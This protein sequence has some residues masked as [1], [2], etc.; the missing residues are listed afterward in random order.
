[1]AA[2]LL[3]RRGRSYELKRKRRQL[4]GEFIAV[5]CA[6]LRGDDAM[7]ALFGHIKGAYTGAA[8]ARRGYLDQADGGVLFLDEIGDLGPDEQ[9][10]LL[11]AIED[12][13]FYPVGADI[14]TSSESAHR[15]HQPRP[16]RGRRRR[17]LP[18]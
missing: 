12:K 10:M 13:V 1:V 5:N 17:P 6:T 16:G 7:S 11:S 2:R 15:R 8:S 18:R 14:A 3:Q 9:A 4:S